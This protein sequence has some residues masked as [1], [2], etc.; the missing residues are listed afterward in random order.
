MQQADVTSAAFIKPSQSASND[1]LVGRQPIYDAG[2][3]I[4][5]YELLFRSNLTSTS[6]Q[7]LDDDKA[8]AHVVV[9]AI[10]DIGLETIAADGLLFVNC[11]RSFLLTDNV[12]PPER[13]VLE[14]L[15]T[16]EFDAVLL[17]RMAELKRR[18]YRLALDDFEFHESKIPALKLVDY[19][20]VEVTN[21]TPEELRATVEQLRPFPCRLLAEKVESEPVLQQCQQLGFE[22]FQ[23]YYLKRP[24]ILTSKHINSSRLAGLRVISESHR[25]DSTVHGLASIVS[26]DPG[27][28]FNLLRLANSALY[29]TRREITTLPEAIARLGIDRV[30]NWAALLVMAS[31]TG[32]PPGYIEFA[33]LRARMCELLALE[34]RSDLSA[35]CFLIGL[36]SLLDSVTGVVMERL[37]A[38]VPL[39][40][41]LKRA[42]IHREGE[43]GQ[44]LRVVTDYERGDWASIRQAGFSEDSVLG[45]FWGS[46][47]FASQTVRT[48]WQ[49]GAHAGADPCLAS[50]P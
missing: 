16:V 33:L 21:R 29:G 35:T 18:G 8:T 30:A 26:S 15:E 32:C 36:L 19:V 1:V 6:A 47:N 45:A 46:T 12:L 44:I 2:R 17:K 37:L 42:L 11:T 24:D 28:T 49:L 5:G 41:H 23:G 25:P 3:R 27:L 48:L 7:V 10:I 9:G 38:S 39:A 50:R 22:L 40:E 13:C 43:A 31:E 14:I 34:R 4:H 20:K